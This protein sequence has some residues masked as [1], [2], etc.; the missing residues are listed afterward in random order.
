MT[1]A[2][3][4]ALRLLDQ[5]SLD[6]SPANLAYAERRV[7]AAGRLA[8]LGAHMVPGVLRVSSVEYG[9]PDMMSAGSMMAAVWL[10]APVHEWQCRAADLLMLEEL[11]LRRP[12]PIRLTL[13]VYRATRWD[14]LRERLSWRLAR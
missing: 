5:R 7:L 1:T 11:A 2:N 10:D 12:K 4:H 8:E 6:P 9:E 3:P 13:A 14:R